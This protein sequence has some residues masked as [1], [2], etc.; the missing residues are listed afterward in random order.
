[1]SVYWAA[2]VV[3]LVLV[4]AVEIARLAARVREFGW[5]TGIAVYDPSQWARNFTFGM[6]YAFTL[7]F[8]QQDPAIG[9]ST[10]NALRNLVLANGAYI[11]L[12]FLAVE[13]AL[14]LL[15]RRSVDDSAPA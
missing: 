6:F 11:V 9:P 10:L 5:R 8:A 13:V 4:E 15:G 3:V 12:F 2:V 7:A 14:M 1:M